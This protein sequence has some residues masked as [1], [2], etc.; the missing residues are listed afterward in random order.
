VPDNVRRVNRVLLVH[1]LIL[2]IA[3][4]EEQ[5]AMAHVSISMLT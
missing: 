1:V 3:P 5:I 4:Q 2:E